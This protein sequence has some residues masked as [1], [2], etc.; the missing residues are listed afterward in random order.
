MF[1]VDAVDL[2]EE[3]DELCVGELKTG[4]PFANPIRQ[5]KPVR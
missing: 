4:K 5:A 1:D 3:F 2:Q